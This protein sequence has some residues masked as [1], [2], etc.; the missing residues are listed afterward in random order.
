VNLSAEEIAK[1]IFDVR[2]EGTLNLEML[3]YPRRYGL[4]SS[5]VDSRIEKVIEFIQKGMPVILLVDDGFFIYQSLHYVVI[6]GYNKRQNV[7]LAHWGTKPERVIGYEKLKR[8]WERAGGWGMVVHSNSSVEV[9]P[10]M[11][12]D[13]GVIYESQGMLDRAEEE[14]RKAIQLKSNFCEPWFNLGNVYYKKGDLNNARESLLK[15]LEVC[16]EKADVYNNLAIV[17]MEM[18]MLSE[19]MESIEKALKIA[20]N[21]QEYLDT[22]GKIE[23]RLRNLK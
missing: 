6:I 1:D 18:G 15:A 4:F 17:L 19:A 2:S 5:I 9:T 3:L 22:R 8:K 14:Y 16:E 12:N 23:L 21:N 13:S 7:F 20:P 11:H 10:E